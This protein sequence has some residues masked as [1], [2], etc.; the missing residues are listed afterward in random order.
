[1]KKLYILLFTI[2]IS[3]VSFGQIV[4]SQAYGGGG[5]S[6]STY[7]NDFI[8]LFNRGTTNVSL[9]GWSVQYASATSMTWSVT[10]LPNFVLAP[11][12]YFLIQQAAGTGGTTPLPTPDAI[13]TVAMSGTNFKVLLSNTITAE[14]VACPNGTQIIDF[15]GFGTANCF[16][17]AVAP[18]LSNTT[19]GIRLNG[20][21]GDSNNNS[22]DFSTGAPNPRNSSSPTSVCSNDPT[23]TLRDGPPNGSTVTADPELPN[24]VTID[25]LTT[26]FTMSSDAGG[27]TGTGGDGFIYWAVNIF[28]STLVDSGY[29]Y[30]SNDP[31]TTYPV[32][33]LV[34][35]VTYSFSAELVD[36]SG[37]PIIPFVKHEFTFTIASYTDVADLAALRASTVDPDTYYRVTGEV[38]NTY[39]RANRN[40]KYF[41][42]ATG[43]I[44]V[45]DVDG[46]ISTTYDEG[47]GVTNIRGRLG[48]FSGL[49]QLIPTE[50][51]WGTPSS[52]GNDIT[53]QVVSIATVAG[54]LGTYE[55]KLVQ[56]NGVTFA[57]GNGANTFSP[58]ISYAINDGTASFFRT[59]FSEANYIGQ[60]IPSGSND[61]VVIVGSFNGDEQFTAR[62]LSDLTLSTK[63]NQIEGFRF[64]PNPTSLGYV[65][66]SSKSQTTMTVNVYD[67]LGKQVINQTV[68]NNRL[69]VST[70]TTGIYIMKISQDDATTTKKLVIK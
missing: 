30:T 19:A 35:G 50:T 49:L 3:T 70:L 13:G 57:D 37:V 59:S 17:T 66:I 62:S 55:S 44:L 33:G 2:L 20:G 29:I 12:Q 61:I 11:G 38:I 65:N 22:I 9:N 7:T 40:Q 16:E 25:F 27:G 45:D 6:G 58:S 10:T 41:Q 53:P 23:L 48:T 32:S 56:L 39:S 8:E 1:M 60:I 5:N 51:D 46:E 63:D 69:N 14:S 26:N 42:D 52:T 67:I 31:N 64:S 43:G 68:T 47:D 24:N 4:I 54:N 36:N 34:N 15:V 21:C 28:G 18:V